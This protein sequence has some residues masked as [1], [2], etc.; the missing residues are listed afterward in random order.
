MSLRLKIILFMLFLFLS[1]IINAIFIFQLESGSEEKSNWVKQTDKVILT[2]ERYLSSMKDTE[3]GQR[4]YLLTSATSYLEPY[5]TGI[6][7][8]TNSFNTLLSLTEDNPI[9]QERLIKIKKNMDLKLVELLETINLTANN[10]NNNKALEIVYQNNGKKY[11]DNIRSDLDEF[12]KLEE[13]LLEKRKRDFRSYK[14]KI[15]ALIGAQITFF[16]LLSVIVILFLNKNL[17]EPLNI[18][19]NGTKRMEAGKEV[20][21]NH[22]VSNDEMGYL[23]SSFYKMHQ[24]VQANKKEL[25]YKANHDELTGLK[26]R[27]TVENEIEKSIES[28]NNSNSKSATLFIDL[29]KFKNLNDTL[30][31]DAGDALL[32]EV[33]T[34]L[35]ESIRSEDIVFRL[36]G[37]EFL[38]LVNNLHGVKE[39]EKIIQNIFNV[40]KEG[41]M[42]KGNKIEISLSIG[43][44]MIPDDTQKNS[45]AI[46]FSD[47]AMYKAKQDDKIDYKFF[48]KSMLK[49][50]ND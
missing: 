8:A 40:C 39:V 48:D 32:K 1:T 49:R 9:Q 38:I 6:R 46:K 31:H 36:G 14:N 27:T 37:D 45:E 16:I 50:S 19:L 29:N 25:E 26:N 42:Y 23:L 30:G 21:V 44:C 7:E 20:N 17:F 13:T 22:I 28:A 35:D 10:N 34:R 47:I 12:I 2:T 41:L 3:T 24:K 33:S 43:V 15:S 18:L 11:M 4:G 5:Y